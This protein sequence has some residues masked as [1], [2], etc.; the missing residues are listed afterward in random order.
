MNSRSI[1]EDEL[2]SFHIFDAENSISRGLRLFGDDGDFI[3][4][5]T[6][7]QGRFPDVR[8]SQDGDK[9]GFEVCHALVRS[10]EFGA[11]NP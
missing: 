10:S 8:P 4:K 3:A 2:A 5:K 6:I 11:I 7:E 1:E 9:T